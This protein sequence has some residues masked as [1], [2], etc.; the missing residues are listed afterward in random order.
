MEEGK[1]QAKNLFKKLLT[2]ASSV[3]YSAE[4]IN[5]T[6]LNKARESYHK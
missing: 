3:F 4:N 6:L 1:K 5:K 2:D